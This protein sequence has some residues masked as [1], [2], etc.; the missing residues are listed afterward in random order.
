VTSPP[1]SWY[2]DPQQP[3]LLR[4]WDGLQWTVYTATVP[5]ATPGT[6]RPVR[7][8]GMASSVLVL[9]VVLLELVLAVLSVPSANRIDDAFSQGGD[10][11]GVFTA[12]DGFA[13]V[14]AAVVIA[15]YVV[16]CLWLRRVRV[17][18]EVLNPYARHVRARGWVWG[19]W[20]CP[21]VSWW[22]PYQIVRDIV[23]ATA[24]GGRS[25]GRGIGRGIGRWW[26][27][28]LIWSLTSYALTRT[29]WDRSVPAVQMVAAIAA[30]IAGVGWVRIVGAVA[31]DQQAYAATHP[32]RTA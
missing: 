1:P 31:C 14:E 28:F 12:Y 9:L 7:V 19:G 32:T 27:F 17:N 20:I 5:A 6:I 15:A 2:L 8:L 3:G 10:G 26:T 11:A 23:R 25:T 16:T 29:G 13:W 4:W 22:F 24:D 18:A 21:V 30:I